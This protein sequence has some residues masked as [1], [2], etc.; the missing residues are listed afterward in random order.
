MFT[1]SDPDHWGNGTGHRQFRAA[2]ERLAAAGF[3]GMRRW[4]LEDNHRARRF[5]ERQG[6]RPDGER[7]VWVPHGHAVEL[8]ELRY[9][10]AL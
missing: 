1:G 4:V 6:M 2:R 10:V 8:P 9:M 5:Y 3:P 7:D